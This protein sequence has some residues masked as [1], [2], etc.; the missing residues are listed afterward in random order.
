M[1]KQPPVIYY[2]SAFFAPIIDH[3]LIRAV[4]GNEALQSSGCLKDT[5]YDIFLQG[6]TSWLFQ[7]LFYFLDLIKYAPGGGRI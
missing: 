3:D 4:M 2:L 1:E 6:S 7:D 5:Y